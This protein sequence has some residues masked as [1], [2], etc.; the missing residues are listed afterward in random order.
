[1]GIV[2]H[3]A[4]LHNVEELLT[5]EDG[6]GFLMSRVPDAVRMRLNPQARE[7]ALNACGCEIRF[8]LKG[9]QAV[10]KLRREP[11]TSVANAV[12]EVY[13]GLFAAP[14]GVSPVVVGRET[15]EIRIDRS[16][17][18]ERLRHLAGRAGHSFDPRVVRIVLPYEWKHRLLAIEGDIAPPEAGQTPDRRYLAYGSSITH[19]G[20]SVTPTGTYAM[21]TARM[22][23]ADLINL[24][25]AGSAELDE[26]IVDY[27]AARPDWDYATLELGINVIDKWTIEQFAAY[28][29]YF[30]ES[31]ARRNEHRWIFV[32][33]LFTMASDD[34]G[35]A[36][37][38]AFRDVVRRKAE[39]MGLPR[40]KHISGRELLTSAAGL[41]AD[42]VHP[43][44]PGM[45]EIAH[46]LVR[47]MNDF[48]S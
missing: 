39:S 21:R 22:L 4:E 13:Y 15:V 42:G 24:G 19:G 5:P 1:M 25:F 8:Q 23:G 16:D 12:A 38:D 28:T 10:V 37:A 33:D 29:D 14:F 18:L 7:T 41:S 40:L 48:I 17:N 47:R 34:A 46:N 2:F 3:Q 30:L 44:P 45:E 20:S 35:N 6:E 43:S 26:A 27:I 31:V 32:I 36:K 11:G 9:E